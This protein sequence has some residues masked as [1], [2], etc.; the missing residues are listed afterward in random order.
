M[1]LTLCAQYNGFPPRNFSLLEQKDNEYVDS[2][3]THMLV[4]L[5]LTVSEQPAQWK[6]YVQRLLALNKTMFAG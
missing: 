2:Y 5:N 1:N 4:R 3:I 6:A